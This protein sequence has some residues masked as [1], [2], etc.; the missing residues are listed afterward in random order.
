MII[1]WG[2]A[3]FKAFITVTYPRGTCTVTGEGQSY[4]HSGGGTTTFT[5]KKKG[6]YTVK[7]ATGSLSKSGTVTISKLN[8][9]KTI[10]LDYTTYLFKAGTGD[11]SGTTGGWSNAT[12]S[13]SYVQMANSSIYGEPGTTDRYYYTKSK[14]NVSDYK[15]LKFTVTYHNNNTGSFISGSYATFGLLSSSLSVSKGVTFRAGGTYSVDLSSV[16][17][18]YYVGALIAAR[19]SYDETCTVTVKA[20][21]IWLE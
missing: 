2:D 3:P 6:T 21:N 20:T 9:A 18:S 11:Y 16:T 10:S 7:A 8:E 17:G 14:V 5:V 13:T 12:V 15:T 1:N 4:T 19:R